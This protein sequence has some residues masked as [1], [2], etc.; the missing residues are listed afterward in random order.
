MTKRIAVLGAGAI[1]SCVGAD[2][3]KTGHDVTVIDQWPQHVEA[4]KAAGLRISMPD[5]ELE[6]R[7]DARHL[8][9][10]ASLNR[11]FDLVLMAVKSYDTRWMAELIRPYLAA[12]GTLVAMQNGMNDEAVSDIVGRERTVGC[13]VELS[14]EIY[15]PGIVQRDTTRPGTWFAVGELDGTITPR[16][17]EIR[18]ILSNVAVV[19]VS[20]NI[21]GAKWTKL[22][23][24]SMTMAPFGLT[25]LKNWQA[26][27]LPGMFEISVQLGREAVAVGAALGYQLEPIFGLTPDE[28]AGSTDEVLATAQR[29]LMAHI[30]SN[31]TTAPVHDHI[32]GRRSEIAYITGLVVA[33]GT[34]LGVPTPYNAAVLEIDEQLNTGQLAMAE[35]NV[36]LLKARVASAAGSTQP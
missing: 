19:D 23:A 32:K 31:S 36:D 2:L 18:T 27:E 16:V 22:I 13:V 29:T 5:E 25:G 9:E 10:L 11:T 34:E 4:M 15:T 12:D 6:I 33:R 1:G 26:R 30:G 20:D 21:L 7:V 35:S 8:C 17:E 28:F 24:N 3:T 14:G